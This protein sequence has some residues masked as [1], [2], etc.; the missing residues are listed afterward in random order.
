MRT[1]A[2]VELEQKVTHLSSRFRAHPFTLRPLL[3][4]FDRQHMRG[5]NNTRHCSPV[6]NFGAVLSPTLRTFT[7]AQSR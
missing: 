3:L 5:P 7:P 4:L 2:S 1:S 6:V